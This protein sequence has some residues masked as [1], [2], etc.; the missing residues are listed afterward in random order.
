MTEMSNAKRLA[1]DLADLKTLLRAKMSPASIARALRRSMAWVEAQ[2]ELLA[3]SDGRA[4]RQMGA[5]VI[6]IVEAMPAWNRR[7]GK[8]VY[9]AARIAA[10]RASRRREALGPDAPVGLVYRSFLTWTGGHGACVSIGG[11]ATAFVMTLAKVQ[12]GARIKVALVDGVWAVLP[13]KGES[14]A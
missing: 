3:V 12:P 1:A 11:G 7:A 10:G 6:R 5:G 4:G 9:L 13:A 8:T 2:I 14:A